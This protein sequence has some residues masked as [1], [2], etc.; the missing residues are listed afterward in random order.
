VCEGSWICE[1]ED[2][3]FVSGR[4]AAPLGETKDSDRER[5]V[6]WSAEEGREMARFGEMGKGQLLW[7]R[8]G[9]CFGEGE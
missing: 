8:Q 6:L 9:R 2:L 7:P 3:C 1:G 5:V 4:E